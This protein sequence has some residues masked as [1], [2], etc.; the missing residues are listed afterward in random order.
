VGIHGDRLCRGKEH[1][2][3]CI[4][5][6]TIG[7]GD[8]CPPGTVRDEAG[9]CIGIPQCPTGT[10]LDPVSMM[11]KTIGTFTCPP[12]TKW[13]SVSNS[14]VHDDVKLSILSGNMLYIAIGVVA[15]LLLGKR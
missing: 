12:T 4:M 1:I 5:L 10:A 7:N 11:C 3:W 6:R 15:L 2:G 14:C 9:T 8:G 13:D